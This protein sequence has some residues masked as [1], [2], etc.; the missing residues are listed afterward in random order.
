MK[1]ILSLMLVLITLVSILPVAYAA[2][3]EDQY[4]SPTC[5]ICG[6]TMIMCPECEMA[7]FCPVCNQCMNCDYQAPTL[8]PKPD[9]VHDYTQGTIVEFVAA[10]DESYTIT[11]PAKLAPGQEGI[12]TLNGTWAND[13]IVSVTADSTVTLINSIVSTDKK[14]LNVNFDGIFESGNNIAVQTFTAPIVVDNISNALFGVWNGKFNYNVNISNIDDNTEYT[15]Y[16]YNGVVLPKIPTEEGYSYQYIM[17]LTGTYLENN[18]RS[19]GMEALIGQVDVGYFMQTTTHPRTHFITQY[20]DEALEFSEGKMI[21]YGF[22]PVFDN[23]VFAGTRD[24]AI[25]GPTSW[26][27]CDEIELLWCSHDTIKEDGTIYLK[28]SEPIPVG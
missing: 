10:G 4:V 14:V 18:L 24:E 15:Q 21:A 22:V 23:W 20:G 28:A 9:D 17:K 1:K 12:V 27:L 2:G 13:R 11:V 6:S 25:D 8:D 3:G 16:S 7:P 26:A 5:S 19:L